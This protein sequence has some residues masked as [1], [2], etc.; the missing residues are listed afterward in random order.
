MKK[1]SSLSSSVAVLTICDRYGYLIL[2]R[3]L[4]AQIYYGEFKNL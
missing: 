3:M 1:L 4:L 2:G